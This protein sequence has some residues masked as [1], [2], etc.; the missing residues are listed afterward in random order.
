MRAVVTSELSPI[1][2]GMPGYK[3]SHLVAPPGF[4]RGKLVGFQQRFPGWW[5][6]ECNQ[7]A[8]GRAAGW[9]GGRPEIIRLA[10]WRADR[11]I[12]VSNEKLDIATSKSLFEDRSTS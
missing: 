6:R 10:V 7:F 2:V 12:C 11:L 8:P 5:T 1:D 4:G 9:N 3:V